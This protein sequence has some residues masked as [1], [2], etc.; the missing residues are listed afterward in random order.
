MVGARFCQLL[1]E[2][3]PSH[4]CRII[5]FGEEPVPAY[6]RIRLSKLIGSTSV[7]DLTLLPIE[8]YRAHEIE[9]HVGDP[10]VHIDSEARTV[11]SAQGIVVAYDSLVLA[12]GSAAAVPAVCGA[13]NA[14]VLRTAADAAALRDRLAGAKHVAVVGGGLL[15]LEAATGIRSQGSEVSVIETARNLMPRQLDTAAAGVLARL[16]EGRGIGV[17]VSHRLR[18]ID[19]EGVG[20]RLQFATNPSL[21]VDAVVFAVGIR[22]RN[23][24][25]REAGLAIAEENGG[26]IVNDAMA[27]S[28]P[29]IY[30][31]GDCASHRGEVYG[32]VGPGYEM[33][34]VLAERLAGG[35]AQFGGGDRSA[36]LVIGDIRVSTIGDLDRPGP[37]ARWTR[38]GR[39]RSL[40][41]DRGRLVGARAIGRWPRMA[42]VERA[43]AD[44]ESVNGRAVRKFIRS[45]EPWSPRA[46][47]PASWSEETTVCYCTGAS[48][49]DVKRAVAAGASCAADVADRTR[50][51]TVCGSCEPVLAALCAG[52]EATVRR[53]RGLAW[54]SLAALCVCAAI[55]MLDPIPFA[56][57]V[58]APNRWLSD[59]W[60]DA[61][62]K[63]LTGFVLLGT[64]AVA[65]LVLSARKR[66]RWLRR[67]RIAGFQVFH[68]AAG[69]VCAGLVVVHTGMHLGENLNRWLMLVFLATVATGGLLGLAVTLTGRMGATRAIGTFKPAITWIHLVALWALLV[70]IGF[71]IFSVYY[72]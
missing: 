55:L 61:A 57:S 60:R 19:V 39:Y 49:G 15:G 3:I 36:R 44:G 59:L 16:L 46:A 11:E 51:S 65:T 5:V 4:G 28:E 33:A 72:F 37:E 20:Y 26:I 62:S 48:V 12:T 7:D 9:L 58:R 45:G 21:V 2:R 52:G 71:H 70:L 43:I 24:L 22:P 67:G 17:R 68:A 13:D 56:D 23:Q 31:I 35:Y 10:V 34:R 27:T 6:D 64:G 66:L 8:W 54:L 42:E 63:K 47:S 18:S 53:G 69:I 41:L 50:A 14:L 1:T 32:L 40:L 30:A 25:A 29:G 38:D